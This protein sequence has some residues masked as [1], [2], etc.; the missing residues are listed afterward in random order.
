MS[1]FYIGQGDTA[2]PLFDTLRKADGSPANL[3][4][5]SVVFRLVPLRGGAPIVNN[6][7][8]VIDDAVA[9]EIHRDWIAGETVNAGDFLGQWI[10]T[11][12]GGKVQTFPNV[13][14]LLITISPDAATTAGRYLTLDELKKTLKLTGKDYADRELEISISAAADALD[15]VYGG[16]WTLGAA[17]EARYFTPAHSKT[18]IDLRQVQAVTA[19]ELDEAGGGTYSRTLTFD[20]DYQLQYRGSKASS[21]PW[22]ALRLLRSGFAYIAAFDDPV[23]RPYPWG[24]DSLRITGTWGWSETPPGVKV[25]ATIIATRMV[26]RS[27]DAPF[28]VVG[29]DVEGNTQRAVTIAKDPEVQFAMTAPRGLRRHVV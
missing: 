21:P 3:T 5:A 17:G 22:D 19:V 25:A 16:P 23:K 14:F 15:V 28:G 11:F 9:G 1:D 18:V 2:S 6:L 8:A 26:R 13:G 20:V 29:F 12:T 7:P 27:R 10:V 4:G 24:V